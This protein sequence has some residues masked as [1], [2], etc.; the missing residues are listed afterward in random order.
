[1][2]GHSEP[3]DPS[4]A[5]TA[6]GGNE[7]LPDGVAAVIAKASSVYIHE[8]PL[9][10]PTQTSKNILTYILRANFPEVLTTAHPGLNVFTPPPALWNSATTLDL[11][12]SGS[13]NIVDDAI[14]K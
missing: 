14:R 13:K 1:M 2:R 10:G 4:E 11:E 6:W 7:H 9:P 8:F 12:L 5:V 3:E